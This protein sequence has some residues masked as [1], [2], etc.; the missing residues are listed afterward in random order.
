MQYFS[1]D[2]FCTVIYHDQML[3]SRQCE[4]F[5]AV[6]Q[7][8]SYGQ[9]PV[10]RITTGTGMEQA[11]LE[12]AIELGCQVLCKLLCNN[13]WCNFMCFQSYITITEGVNSFFDIKIAVKVRTSQR[14]RDR[15]FLIFVEKMSNLENN[16]FSEEAFN[17]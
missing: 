7:A 6:N 1:K 8:I 2:N 15:L 3:N 12:L 5:D 16:R 9:L 14:R 10:I 17:C 11:H 4:L 13:N